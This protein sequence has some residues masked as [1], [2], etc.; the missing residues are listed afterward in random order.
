MR[1]QD[2]KRDRFKKVAGKRVQKVLDTIDSLAKCAN[3]NNYD[4]EDEDVTKMLR[5][6]KEKV[7][8]LEMA[9]TS[10]TKSIKNIFKF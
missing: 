8:I 1:N 6:L 3:R 7:K 4:Y 5:A 2:I 9:Y 10:N